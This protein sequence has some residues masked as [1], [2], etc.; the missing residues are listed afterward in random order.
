MAK[1]RTEEKDLGGA[2]ENEKERGRLG[3][4]DSA[5]PGSKKSN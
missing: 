3:G 2:E 1:Q 4:I 5:Q